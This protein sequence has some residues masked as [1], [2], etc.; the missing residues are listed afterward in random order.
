MHGKTSHLEVDGLL[1]HLAQPQAVASP[2]ETRPEGRHLPAGETGVQRLDAWPSCLTL[3]LC[4]SQAILWI[5]FQNPSEQIA[6]G[7]LGSK[8]LDRKYTVVALGILT[9]VIYLMY[10]SIVMYVNVVALCVCVCG[11]LCC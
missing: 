10:I 9:S 8:D 3:P 1:L 11:S 6:M 4:R 7:G 2:A 5:S